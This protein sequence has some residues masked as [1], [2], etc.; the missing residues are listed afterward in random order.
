[1]LKKHLYFIVASSYVIECITDNWES[2]FNII[3]DS[4]WNKEAKYSAQNFMFEWC[5]TFGRIRAATGIVRKPTKTYLKYYDKFLLKMIKPNYFIDS[6]WL[7]YFWHQRIR[8]PDYFWHQEYKV[9][10]ECI[11]IISTRYQWYFLPRE[12]Y[13]ASE[14]KGN[15]RISGIRG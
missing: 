3:F 1:M 15:G 14:A 13:L 4:I 8:F 9:S 11:T 10:G 6:N 2:C 7:C 5:T 12:L